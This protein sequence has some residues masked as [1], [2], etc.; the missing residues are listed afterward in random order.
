VRRCLVFDDNYVVVKQT[1]PSPTSLLT[2]QQNGRARRGG[3]GG[4]LCFDDNYVVSSQPTV[5]K[6][7]CPL[8]AKWPG[9]GEG[10]CYDDNMF[11]R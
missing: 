2:L 7:S 8:P 4:G 10:L 9:Q 3:F 11:V 5:Q 1:Q 6:A